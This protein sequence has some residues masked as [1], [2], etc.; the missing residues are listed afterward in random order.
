MKKETAT[1][2]WFLEKAKKD[3]NTLLDRLKYLAKNAKRRS[4]EENAMGTWGWIDEILE[5]IEKYQIA[6]K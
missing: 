4:E 3:R 5:E 1:E 6:P 2:A